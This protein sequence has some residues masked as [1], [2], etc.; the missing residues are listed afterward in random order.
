[1]RTAKSLPREFLVFPQPEFRLE[2]ELPHISPSL[3]GYTFLPIKGLSFVKALKDP[4][5][6]HHPQNRGTLNPDRLITKITH[7]HTPTHPSSP[8]FSSHL[9]TLILILVLEPAGNFPYIFMSLAMHLKRCLLYF[10]KTFIGV[11]PREGFWVMWLALLL[12][13]KST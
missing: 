3:E 6:P 11:L 9:V 4:N 1:M 2:Q 12:E 5:P 10:Y 8:N 7:T 13:T